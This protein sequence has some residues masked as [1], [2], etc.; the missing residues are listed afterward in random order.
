MGSP[1]L[2]TI[3]A[4]AGAFSY[5]PAPDG[6]IWLVRYDVPQR[7]L[8]LAAGADSATAVAD[9]SGPVQWIANVTGAPVAIVGDTM[10]EWF[11]PADSVLRRLVVGTA[12]PLRRISAVPGAR[13]FVA[14]IE[15]GWDLFGDP[16]NFWLYELP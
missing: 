14:E 1:T 15:R 8:H 6:G 9:Y 2:T 3:A 11:E 16:A 4:T 13:R 12:G 10:V 7:L 5:A